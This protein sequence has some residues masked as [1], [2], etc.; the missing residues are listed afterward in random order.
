MVLLSYWFFEYCLGLLLLFKKH[1]V[2]STASSEQSF[3]L[4]VSYEMQKLINLYK[5][6]LNTKPKT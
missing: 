2:V 1:F 3:S 6:T 4:K 5:A